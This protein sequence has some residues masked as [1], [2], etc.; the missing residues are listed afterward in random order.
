MRIVSVL[1]T[2]AKDKSPEAPK[3]VWGKIWAYISGDK[4]DNDFG[5]GKYLPLQTNFTITSADIAAL[6]EYIREG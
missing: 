6:T 1:D 3:T 2:V 4:N 5:G